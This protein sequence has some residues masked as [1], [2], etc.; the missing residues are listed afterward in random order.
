MKPIKEC[1]T[2]KHRVNGCC[3]NEDWVNG[4]FK[5]YLALLADLIGNIEAVTVGDHFCCPKHANPTN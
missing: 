1:Q 2:C 5:Q 3:T 4:P